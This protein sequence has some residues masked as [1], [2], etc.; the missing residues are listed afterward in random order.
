MS[1][2]R[3]SVLLCTILCTGRLNFPR[4]TPSL[5]LKIREFLDNE[6]YPDDSEGIFDV[7]ARDEPKEGVPGNGKL[8]FSLQF[9]GNVFGNSQSNHDWSSHATTTTSLPRAIADIVAPDW[10]AYVGCCSRLCCELSYRHTRRTFLKQSA[11]FM[12]VT[13]WCGLRDPR[14]QLANSGAYVGYFST[15]CMSSLGYIIHRLGQVQAERGPD[16][17]RVVE[18]TKS[19]EYGRREYAHSEQIWIPGFSNVPL[20]IAA[21]DNECK[22]GATGCDMRGAMPG[23]VQA[24]Q[25]LAEKLSCPFIHVKDLDSASTNGFLAV[26]D[27]LVEECHRLDR[28]ARFGPISVPRG[29]QAQAELH[30]RDLSGEQGE[31]LRGERVKRGIGCCVT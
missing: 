31:H 21:I 12:P 16:S 15:H 26:F 13:D 18:R 25:K 1:A 14:R 3:E 17:F 24:G 20:V 9:L 4:L 11:F 22:C 28:I 2:S 23:A 5:W 10:R 29:A 6:L 27:A 8:S 19:I 30:F 7:S